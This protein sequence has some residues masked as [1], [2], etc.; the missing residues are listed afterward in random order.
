MNCKAL[1]KFVDAT[2]D[3]AITLFILGF[4]CSRSNG[5]DFCLLP[6]LSFLDF[7]LVEDVE[8]LL[9]KGTEE[10]TEVRG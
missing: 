5:L 7:L 4:S 9:G 2:E 3:S 8:T 6:F 10:P 1:S